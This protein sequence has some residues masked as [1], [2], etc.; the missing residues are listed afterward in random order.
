MSSAT[1]VNAVLVFP[2]KYMSSYVFG[3]VYRHSRWLYFPAAFLIKTTLGQLLLLLLLPFAIKFRHA[4]RHRELLFLL[5]ASAVYFL[6]AVQSGFNIGARHILPVYSFLIILAAFA[7][8]Q[9]LERGGGGVIQLSCCSCS[10]WFHR[11]A[12]SPTTY[13]MQMSSGGTGEYIEV[14]NRFQRRL[15]AATQID[16]EIFGWARD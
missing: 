13:R 6:A 1:R 14:A 5:V 15:G 16:E 12:H 3:T 4:Q 10:R 7:A 8:W 2:V 9:L 11:C